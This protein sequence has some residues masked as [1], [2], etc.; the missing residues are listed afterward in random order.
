[1]GDLLG[2]TVVG[3]LVGKADVGILEGDA[4]GFNVGRTDGARDGIKVGDFDGMELCGEVDG[5]ELCGEVDGREL[6][7]RVGL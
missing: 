2:L 6:G 4:W 5:R 1:M 7:L 3:V